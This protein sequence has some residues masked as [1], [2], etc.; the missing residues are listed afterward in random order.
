MRF[1][2]WLVILSISAVTLAWVMSSNNG[3]VVLYWNQLRMDLS[4]NMALMI[5]VGVNL[6]LF[7]CLR[8]INELINL[9]LKAKIYRSRQR[10]IRASQDLIIGI[11]HLFAGRFTKAIK[12]AHS[13]SLYHHT[14]NVALMMIVYANQQLKNNQQRDDALEQITDP[15][16]LQAKLILQA[17]NLLDDRKPDEVLSIVKQLQEKGARQFLVQNIAMRAN[18]L[19]KNWLEVVRLANNL[20]KRN[21]LS[22][23]MADA[24]M[25]EGM[26]QLLITKQ[27]T[28]QTLFK[29]WLELSVTDR[30]DP[31]WLKLFIQGFIQIN[32]V[33]HAKQLLQE[34]FA[35][36]VFAEL[37]LLLPSYS[38]LP[39]VKISESV[40]Q[41]ERYLAQNRANPYL[42]FT[43]AELCFMQQLW[44]KSI[45]CFESVLSSPRADR[46]MKIQTHFRLFN[47]FEAIE[48][49]QQSAVHQ[50]AL[51]EQL[52]KKI[53]PA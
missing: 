38:K 52:N 13:A 6:I 30:A 48:N 23:L 2:I 32:D 33:T 51:V 14:K 42:Q 9:P 46:D 5:V 44:G 39:G 22:P 16:N 47:I 45:A 50:K 4:L 43:L 8:L 49:A 10:G 1:V 17:Q 11:D 24:R 34:G 31:A 7:F 29:Q 27:Y 12:A 28:S 3:H 18:Q 20:K 26:N 15:E 40:I 21:F 19:A 53:I 35:K 25:F 37:L 41:V 36:G